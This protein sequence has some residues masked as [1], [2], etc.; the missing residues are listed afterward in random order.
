MVG[1]W[2]SLSPFQNYEQPFWTEDLQAASGGR[3]DADFKSMSTLGIKGYETISLLKRGVFDFGH[4]TIAYV[5]GN[6]PE[7]EGMDLA[8]VAT[9]MKTSRR[10]AEAYK[11]TVNAHLAETE[12]VVMLA[13]YPFSSQYIFCKDEISGLDDL[14]GKKIRTSSATHADFITGVGATNVTIPFAEVVSALQK[15]VVDC[16]VT[17]SMSAYGAGWAE[18]VHT[19]YALP[20]NM[21]LSA[22]FV[23]KASWDALDPETRDLL[24]RT[25]GVWEEHAWAG[26]SEE[27]A[28]GLVCLVGE[29][30]C[31]AGAS[32]GLTLVEPT[33]EDMERRKSILHTHVFTNWVERCGAGCADVWNETVG[34][35]AGFKIGQ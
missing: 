21:G 10:N 12:G 29:G 15:G 5:T 30:D 11:E 24:V 27:D 8:G 18:I 2:S 32:A 7:M 16:A 3:L 9:D 23:G 4:A 28:N 31:F 1:T 25:I 33:V 6:V 35:V 20:L 14:K 22:M 26:L 34:K 13:V 17:G 19:V